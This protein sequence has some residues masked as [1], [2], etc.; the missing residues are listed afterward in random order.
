MATYIA[1]LRGI[2][3]GRGKVVKMERLRTS[4]ATLGVRCDQHLC[5]KR[6]RSF[7]I[8]TKVAD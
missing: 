8:G 1:M 3:V 6:Q 7:S 2:N 4:F 5:A